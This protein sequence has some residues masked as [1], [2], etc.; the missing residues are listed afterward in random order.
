[1][2]Q[3]KWRLGS[4]IRYNIRRTLDERYI[5]SKADTLA[6]VEMNDYL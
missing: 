6:F 4:G 5:E 3:M 2:D 1:M